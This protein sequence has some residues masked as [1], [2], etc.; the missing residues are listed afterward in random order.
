MLI[1]PIVIGT[2]IWVYFDA[3]EIGVKKVEGKSVVNP[4][5]VA[6]L[7]GCLLLWIV[8]FPIYLAKRAGFKERLRKAGQSAQPPSVKHDELHQPRL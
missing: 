5:P 7:I 2:S 3:K 8:V 6:W 4:G 1:V